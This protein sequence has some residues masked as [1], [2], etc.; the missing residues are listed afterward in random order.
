MINLRPLTRFSQWPLR[1]VTRSLFFV[2]LVGY[3]GAI[4]AGSQVILA[5]T[6][7][8]QFFDQSAR[9]LAFGCVFTYIS[10]T[11]TAL[12]TYTDSTGATLN[13]NPVPLSA[14]GSA[15][16]WI[17]AGLAYTFR[18]KA[19]GGTNCASGTTLYTVNGI[20]GGVS[21]LTTVIPYSS[22][23][24]FQDASQNQL[25]TLTLTGNASSL[26]LTVVGILPPGVI[27]FQITQD[28]AG[29]HTFAWPAN[30]IG[31]C[32]IGSAANQVTTQT[33]IWNGTNATAVG[34]CVTGNGPNI[35][36]GVATGF[37]YVSTIATGTPPFLVSSLTQVA[38]LNSNFLEGGD[39]A[40]PG[41]IGA[42]APN[43]G[44]FSTLEATASLKLNGSTVQTGIQGSDTK[45][46]TTN[47]TVANGATACGD[48][49]GGFTTSGCTS[50]GANTPQRLVLGAPVGLSINT[51]T[52]VLTE[53]VTFPSA[54]GTYRADVRYGAWA[55]AGSNICSA[56]VIDTTNNRAFALSGQNSNGSGFIGLSGSEISSQT[57]AA[58][59][60]ATFT[61]QLQCNA[62]ST[63]TVNGSLTFSP[64]QATYLSVTPISS[65]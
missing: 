37:Q 18:V 29:S 9:P 10:G 63:A 35:S 41:T 45:L 52:I 11:T 2:L 56:E 59:A 27:T 65:N 54:S 36:L 23:V 34:P 7:Q 55:T 26:P 5:P 53:S 42:T 8:L 1:S 25:F 49:Q 50:G 24:T 33:F 32:T 3:F 46:A 44:K 47:G 20:G 30:V 21:V 40:S 48:A 39:W 28:A 19:A 51:Q 14:G 31:G 6:P 60:V 43:T 64:N 15:N 12:A 16:I 61:L 22:T 57:Y 38:N 13:P 4:D 17:Q 58:G 62:A